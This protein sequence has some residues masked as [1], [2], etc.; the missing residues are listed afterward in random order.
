MIVSKLARQEAEEERE[1]LSRPEPTKQSKKETHSLP[2]AIDYLE[3]KPELFLN[4][5]YE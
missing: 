5:M 2:C 3:Q 4:A 1:R